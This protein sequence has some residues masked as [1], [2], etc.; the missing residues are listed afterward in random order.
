MGAGDEGRRLK[1]YINRGE[2]LTHRTTVGF[3]IDEKEDNSWR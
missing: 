1:Y 3:A 2:G